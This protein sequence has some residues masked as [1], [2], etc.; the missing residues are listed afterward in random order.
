M[1]P[2][3][4]RDS[5]S[6]SEFKGLADHLATFRVADPALTAAN[7][8]KADLS[9]RF[10]AIERMFSLL[11][12]NQL[13]SKLTLCRRYCSSVSCPSSLSRQSCQDGFRSYLRSTLLDHSKLPCVNRVYVRLLFDHQEAFLANL[14]LA[15]SAL[16]RGCCPNLLVEELNVPSLCYPSLW[17][18]AHAI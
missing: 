12:A 18:Q 11:S 4:S 7:L 5:L 3:M 9:R 15:S 17:C 2:G 1:S 13:E 8:C 14:C 10:E 6:R 16:S